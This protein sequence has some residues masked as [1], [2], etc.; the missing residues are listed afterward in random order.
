[1]STFQ[2]FAMNQ[3]TNQKTF[4][5][6]LRTPKSKKMR[7]REITVYSIYISIK[8]MNID[9]HLID[10][11]H[12]INS[13]NQ[14]MIL[15]LWASSVK[16]CVFFTTKTV[17]HC[18]IYFCPV[19]EWFLL[20]ILKHSYIFIVDNEIQ[21]QMSYHPVYQTCFYTP[22]HSPSPATHTFIFPHFSFVG[23]ISWLWHSL[24]RNCLS[25][26]PLPQIRRGMWSHDVLH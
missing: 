24:S 6:I 4:K 22:T 25:W 16:T 10:I 13:K 17:Q 18:F 21:K 26:N 12:T 3:K 8:Y 7:M 5:F 19:S 20:M 14:K 15:R 2:N 1:M 23:I 9:V 11:K